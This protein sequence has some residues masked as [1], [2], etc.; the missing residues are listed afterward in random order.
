MEQLATMVGDNLANPGATVDSATAGTLVD[1]DLVD[2]DASRLQGAWSGVITGTGI[3]QARRISGFTASSDSAAIVPNWTTTPAAADRY[4]ISS[5]WSPFQHDQA[6]RQGQRIG[7]YTNFKELVDRTIILGSPL[8]NG[9]F[10]QWSGGAAAAPD[11]WTASGAGL[12]TAR[13]ATIIRNG[14]FSLKMS[15]STAEARE[16]QI[17]SAG[18]YLGLTVT[19]RGWVYTRTAADATLRITARDSNGT[20]LAGGTISASPSATG[21]RYLELAGYTVPAAAADLAIDLLHA[22]NG[23][24]IYWSS[25]WPD[26]GLPAGMSYLLDADQAILWL[27]D[28]LRMS[29]GPVGD[30]TG[31]AAD[32]FLRSIPKGAWRLLRQPT[33]R[34]EI[35][36]DGYAGHVLS[37]DAWANH[38]DLTA[39]ATAWTGNPEA[40]LWRAAQVLGSMA[41]DGAMMEHYRSLGDDYDRRFAE[42]LRGY[43]R[44]EVN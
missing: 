30:G 2:A 41:G 20:A 29:A 15:G 22:A 26:P 37:L 21:W 27:P 13:E 16:R 14:L 3:G 33:R 24:E 35:D 6:L 5:R 19:L 18:P 40:L 42:R 43:T 1:S 17:I 36:V 34:L 23:N 44:V 7:A 28:D 10:D 12:V 25:V 32:R 38:A 4:F 39:Y 31:N 9:T 11:G 8:Q